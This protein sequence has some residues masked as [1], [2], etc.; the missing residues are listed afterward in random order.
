MASLSS[1]TIGT[2]TL[3]PNFEPNTLNYTVHAH[4]APASPSIQVSYTLDEMA[5]GATV[6][7]S[8]ST[9]TQH[10]VALSQDN[11]L[12]FIGYGNQAYLIVTVHNSVIDMTR[13]YRVN[14]I[15]SAT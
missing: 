14:L 10:Y 1:L 13:E 15:N 2:L 7:M 8:I 6:E 3:E 5:A 12:L 9:G 11:K 4:V